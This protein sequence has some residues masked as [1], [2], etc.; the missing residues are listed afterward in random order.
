MNSGQNKRV[1]VHIKSKELEKL[2]EQYGAEKREALVE[3]SLAMFF[4]AQSRCG[5]DLL[6]TPIR[7]WIRP[8][9]HQG[10]EIIEK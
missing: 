9:M 6:Q 5:F 10:A 2:L 1:D 4:S 8:G 3:K 7:I